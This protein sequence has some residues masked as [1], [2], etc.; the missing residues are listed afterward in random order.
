MAESAWMT[1]LAPEHAL[2]T[3]VDRKI[4]IALVGGRESH[5]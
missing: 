2:S 4:P 1:L 5:A 3:Q